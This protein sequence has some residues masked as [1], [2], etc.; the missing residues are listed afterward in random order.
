MTPGACKPR[1]ERTTGAPG[2]GRRLGGN[3]DAS[4]RPSITSTSE[5]S[6]SALVAACAGDLAV[7]Q[8]GDSVREVEHL[9]Q[10][11]DEQDRLALPGQRPHDL[12]QTGGLRP[13]QRGS[14]LV[15]DHDLRRA[16]QRSQDLD[17]LL[18]G[19]PQRSCGDITV[20]IKTR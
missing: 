6:V 5:S 1:T 10:C 19:D 9:A 16:R 11:E 14:R 3:V 17:L 7:T 8:D 15:H 13:A 12:V 4:D 2:S 20:E 18:I